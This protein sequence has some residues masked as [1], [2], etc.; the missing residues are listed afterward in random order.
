MNKFTIRY[1]IKINDLEYH[2]IISEI[3]SFRI[4]Q[5]MGLENWLALI[6]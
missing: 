2:K 5:D 4:L 6:D 3:I 1:T